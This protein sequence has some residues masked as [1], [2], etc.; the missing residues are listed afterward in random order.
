MLDFCIR[1]VYYTNHDANEDKSPKTAGKVIPFRFCFDRQEGGF[2]F[3]D[4]GYDI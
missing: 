2:L 3:E 1:L 4:I